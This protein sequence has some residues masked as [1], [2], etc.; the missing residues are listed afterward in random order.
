MLSKYKTK[1]GYI[2]R[3]GNRVYYSGYQED[4]DGIFEV[5]NIWPCRKYGVEIH[6]KEL[7]G[8]REKFLAP[9]MFDS[10]LACRYRPIG[11]RN[12]KTNKKKGGDKNTP[13]PFLKS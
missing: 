5:Y 7:F 3:K 10:G 11:V 8:E 13:P 6:L 9:Y 1:E 12:K 4:G 2:I